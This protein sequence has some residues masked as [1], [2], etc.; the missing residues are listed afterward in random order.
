MG[1]TTSTTSPGTPFGDWAP[2]SISTSA[3]ALL[4]VMVTL[5]LGF[6]LTVLLPVV[7][8]L[9]SSPDVFL[10]APVPAWAAASAAGAACTVFGVMVSVC[11]AASAAGAACT[12]FGVMVS[13]CPAASVAGSASS[14]CA[15]GVLSSA[16]AASP[17]GCVSWVSATGAAAAASAGR[18]TEVVRTI[19]ASASVSPFFQML[20]FISLFLLILPILR[21][22]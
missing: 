18:E 6:S 17:P 2:T 9:L 15:A 16:G 8:P 13:V 7:L 14:T 19:A 20:F 22:G 3:L 5:V 10:S 12:V 4:G 1:S 11:P 21:C